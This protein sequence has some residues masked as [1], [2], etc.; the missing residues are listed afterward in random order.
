[1]DSSL[2]HT[3]WSIRLTTKML[4][5]S[6]RQ[7]ASRA[8]T[9]ATSSSHGRATAPQSAAPTSGKRAAGAKRSTEKTEQGP[10]PSVAAPNRKRTKASVENNG[11]SIPTTSSLLGT[12]SSL[13]PSQV[14]AELE[15]SA[16][17]TVRIR[18]HIYMRTPVWSIFA[19]V[20]LSARLNANLASR[21]RPTMA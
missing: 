17:R 7:L 2:S 21:M 11:S 13:S 3:N 15:V 19:V 20:S 14:V 18:S 1:M 5:R 9:S 4:R 16:N 12:G 8:A 10:E 6:A